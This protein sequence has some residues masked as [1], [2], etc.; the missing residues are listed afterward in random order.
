M[1]LQLNMHVFLWA[2]WNREQNDY[3]NNSSQ[4]LFL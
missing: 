4:L 1:G 2:K 3:P